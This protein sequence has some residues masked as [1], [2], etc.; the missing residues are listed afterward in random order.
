MLRKHLIFNKLFGLSEP[1]PH[2]RLLLVLIVL[3]PHFIIF[4]VMRSSHE[5][6][7]T[8][9]LPDHTYPQVWVPTEWAR[10]ILATGGVEPDRLRVRD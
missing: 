6:F 3:C 9:F 2:S 10:S 8:T 7:D 4:A 1:A 5:R